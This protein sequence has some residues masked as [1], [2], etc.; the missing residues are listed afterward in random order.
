MPGQASDPTLCHRPEQNSR[1]FRGRS[2]IALGHQVQ[3][4]FPSGVVRLCKKW[5]LRDD[6]GDRASA[7]FS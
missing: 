6:Q 3:L 5:A 2:K 7:I 4:V 1:E